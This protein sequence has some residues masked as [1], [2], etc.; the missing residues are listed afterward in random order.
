M[1][2]TTRPTNSSTLDPAFIGGAV[3]LIARPLSPVSMCG[4]RT[5][6]TVTPAFRCSSRNAVS[7]PDSAHL[8]AV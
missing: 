4:G 3:P 1:P 6:N 7:H 8:L 2:S 5:S